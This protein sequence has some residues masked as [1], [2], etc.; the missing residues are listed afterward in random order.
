MD[1]HPLKLVSEVGAQLCRVTRPGKDSLV[2]SLR[3]VTD[4]LAR[5]EHTSSLENSAKA[6]AHRKQAVALNPLKEAVVKRGLHRHA[7]R[8]VKLL[9]SVCVAELF[10]IQ[11]P[12]TPFADK[13]LG[14]RI[15]QCVVVVALRLLFFIVTVF[16][17]VKDVFKLLL[18][19]FSELGD[20]DSP[21]F[22]KRASVLETVAKCECYV[23][24]L[25]IGSG[26]LVHEMF[27][28]FFSVARGHRHSSVER[29]ILLIMS[30]ILNEEPS[31]RLTDI[32][33]QNLVKDEEAPSQLAVLI[34]HKCVDAL[35]P[36]ICRFLT[37]CFLERDAVESELK[38]SYHDVFFK[39]CKH[40]PQ[41]L[42]NVIPYLTE[43]LRTD[44]VDI[45]LKA[46]KLLGKLLALRGDYFAQQHHDLLVEFKNRFSDK[47][48]DI[49]RSALQ[50]A[51]A[52]YIANPQ[53]K[54]SEEILAAFQGRLL[55]LNEDVRTQAV[56]SICDL[57]SANMKLF[58]PGLIL[59]ATERLRDKKLSVRKKVLMELMKLYRD[60]CSK[61]SECHMAITDHFEQ[62]PTKVLM[63]CYI[64]SK[65]FRFQFMENVLGEDLFPANLSAE[66][67]SK[68][69]VHIV[70]LFTPLHWK[71]LSSVLSQKS[72]LQTEMQT[73]LSL[74][75]K[76]KGTSLEV[77]QSEI[78]KLVLNMS[79]LFPDPS[80]AEDCFNSL[81][82]IKD[83]N[84]FSTL[85][86]LLKDSTITGVQENR[87]KLLKVIGDKHPQRDFLQLLSSKCAFNLFNSEIIRCILV[88]ISSNMLQ[89][90]QKEASAKLL[91]TV[92]SVS[93]FLLRGTE[94]EVLML[95]EDDTLTA[96]LTEVLAKAGSHISVKFSDFYPFLKRSC[97]EGTRVQAKHAISAIASLAGSSKQA[98]FSQLC[99]ELVNS[100]R[101]GWNTSTL[102]QSLGCIM[103]HSVSAFE[104]HGEEIRSY[105]FDIIFKL[106]QS[107]EPTCS[108][109]ML[110]CTDSCQL[111]IFALKTLVRSFLSGK[112]SHIN[113]KI[114]EMLGLLLKM[115]QTGDTSDGV[116][117]CAS[118]KP[119]IRLA[120]AKSI[121][122]LSKRWDLH[123]S[124]RIFQLTILMAKDPSPVVR[125]S[126]LHKTY[127]LLTIHAIPMRY[128]CAF[129]LAACSPCEDLHDAS[130]RYMRDFIKY[131]VKKSQFKQMSAGQR[132]PITD[133]PAYMIV[134][135]I[136]ILAHDESFP[137]EDCQDEQVYA[138][139]CSPLFW[140]I[141]EL[142]RST[143]MDSSLDFVD[144]TISRLLWFF[145]AM[146]KAEDAVD[147]QGT[148]VGSK[149]RILADIGISIVNSLQH[150]S[151]SVSPTPGPVFLPCSLYKLSPVK[152]YNEV[153]LKFV[154]SSSDQQ[155]FFSRLI[156][157]LNSEVVKHAGT[158][159]KRGRD[160][161]EDKLQ[162]GDVEY[163]S[164][165]LASK[166][167]IHLQTLI[168]PEAEA[169]FPV[170]VSL[171]RLLEQAL[172]PS[173][174]S[175]QV[176][177]DHTATEI[178][179]GCASTFQKSILSN[180]PILSN[181][182][183]VAPSVLQ[184]DVLQQQSD[185]N[186][187]SLQA[188]SSGFNRQPEKS[189]SKHIKFSSPVATRFSTDTIANSA[190]QP[191]IHETADNSGE[192][193]FSFLDNEICNNAN[194][195][196]SREK[197]NLSRED[198]TTKQSSHGELLACSSL[199]VL[200]GTTNTSGVDARK[201]LK[202]LTNQQQEAKEKKAVKALPKTAETDPSQVVRRSKRLRK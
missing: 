128:A 8:D 72:R 24:M 121:L 173:V 141:Q 140:A 88:N 193:E 156:P 40:E 78:K 120:A 67:R 180:S 152:T 149:L 84:I 55:G 73:F 188:S 49:R 139:F 48:S 192:M 38:E 113:W 150:N 168:S 65:E 33:L 198:L 146:K 107:D 85:E 3:E 200:K 195:N 45:R 39:V 62:I 37:S 9:V 154:S 99:E 201:P 105:I 44:Q 181:S 199:S 163:N 170:D 182:A 77:M 142:T 186:V 116:L 167:H 36:S 22:G 58:P 125:R 71:A 183:T 184:H 7:D 119:Y 175:E 54:V 127:K 166:E 41:M 94:K 97:L 23:I 194:S 20:V 6:E 122:Q 157:I 15:F 46:V 130:S 111:K 176:Y 185:G 74:R 52:C 155:N 63:L 90:K 98:A 109:E 4:A 66:E 161:H 13:Y 187:S 145:R 30:R 57:A 32:I 160:S 104:K 164:Q 114:D 11:A 138:R 89:S 51:K 126:F 34:I 143:N 5:I 14:V 162:S 2:K 108:G 69:W 87:N 158:S 50:C 191:N 82:Q 177:G 136:H 75:K 131:Y 96:M 172:S 64:E 165:S 196:A 80:K 43:E 189:T 21:Y 93:P 144:Y 124:H 132:E 68:H 16:L 101:C 60:Y 169:T 137:H 12:E 91:M 190:S 135:L 79:A 129:A 92:I 76:E 133:D 110:N 95:L 118:D 179:Q 100:L 10:R 178:H 26:E 103:R 29:N 86:L 42:L 70:S 25:D 81:N 153:N 102:L 117:S 197:E 159:N 53:G 112:G 31:Q 27:N 174:E 148:P 123:I 134:F 147:P 17:F 19:T 106:N 151:K 83:C 171:G 1:N 18:G 115:L 28:I 56:A 35:K 61:C 202:Q 59:S 47:S